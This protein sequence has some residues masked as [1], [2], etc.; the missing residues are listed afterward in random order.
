MLD[1]F[2]KFVLINIILSKKMN[3]LFNKINIL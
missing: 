2:S 1:I 3:I